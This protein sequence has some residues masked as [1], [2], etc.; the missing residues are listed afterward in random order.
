MEAA[1]QLLKNTYSTNRTV[2]RDSIPLDIPLCVSI[3][4]TNICNFKCSMCYHGNNEYAEEAKP[5]SNMDMQV[6]DKC[7]SDLKVWKLNVGKKVK[8]I[9]LYSLGEPLIHSEIGNMVKAIKDADV[10]DAI[11]ITTNG[12]LLT[13]EVAKALVDYELDVLRLS[14]YGVSNDKFKNI[15]KSQISPMQIK[16]N[17]KAL[18]EYRNSLGKDK[19]KVYA[20]MLDTFSEENELFLNAYKD[21]AD[22]VGIDEPF[23][24]NS[25]ENDI[26]ENLFG[27]ENAKE[28]HEKSMGTNTANA[29]KSCR[30]PF[31]HM[32]IRNNGS[33]IV[34]CTDWLKEL[35]YGNVMKESLQDL[36][37]SKA[38]YDIRCKM[39]KDRRCFKACA[40]CE[41]PYRDAP[42]DDIDGLDIG[43]LSYRE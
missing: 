25:G 10:C 32:T 24:L 37:E 4:P 18:V 2:L 42:E 36:W 30:Y 27:K 9:K 13:E 20:K 41:I 3:E 29:K 23:H 39:L 33:V 40:N 43:V 34:C 5:L 35:C 15:T 7:I 22:E 12:S 16:D 8:L 31:T 17:L 6:F 28:A 19:P 26:F 38:L 11:E 21:V 1:E 14:V